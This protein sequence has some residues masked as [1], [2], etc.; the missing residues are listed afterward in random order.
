M[1]KAE[2]HCEL[3]GILVKDGVSQSDINVIK[4]D[5]GRSR[6]DPGYWWY[7]NS[8]G[9]QGIVDNAVK[10]GGAGYRYFIRQ[11]NT[12]DPCRVGPACSLTAGNFFNHGFL[13]P[14]RQRLNNNRPEIRGEYELVM[15]HHDSINMYTH[16]D[17]SI[18]KVDWFHA[19]SMRLPDDDPEGQVI[20]VWLFKSSFSTLSIIA[21]EKPSAGGSDVLVGYEIILAGGPLPKKVVTGPV[22]LTADTGPLDSI[23]GSA[24]FLMT[25]FA[26]ENFFHLLVPR[27]DAVSHKSQIEHYVQASTILKEWKHVATLQ[28]PDDVDGTT[29][30]AA[31]FVQN[32]QGTFE[33]VARVTPPN[34][35]GDYLVGY[36][37]LNTEGEWSSPFTL[38]TGGGPIPVTGAP[39]LMESTDDDRD[40]LHL[41]VP[42]EDVTV[43]YIL[44]VSSFGDPNAKW[45]GVAKLSSFQGLTVTAVS[46]VKN[47]DGGFEAVTRAR[48][49]GGEEVAV[50]Y[51]LEPGQTQWSEGTALTANDGP[52][53]G[54]P[55]RPL[56]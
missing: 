56:D 22:R 27:K 35:K 3:G 30:T 10:S 13:P 42:T 21:R 15:A 47:I 6:G 49:P 2:W 38:S 19:D 45:E 40:L 24:P 32:S 50:G 8:R 14:S 12:G 46:L 16:N 7:D 33:A 20:G 29:I 54:I 18:M 55:V 23:D 53:I 1:P 25:N 9:T 34:Q 37:A 36:H 5:P 41:L 43:H 39:I 51:E 26:E 4:R 28:P 44:P 17:A 52:I 11:N 31:A 48:K